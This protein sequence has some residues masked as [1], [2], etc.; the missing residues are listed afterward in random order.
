MPSV[1]F[2]PMMVKQISPKE[3]VLAINYIVPNM[4]ANMMLLMGGWRMPLQSTIFLFLESLKNRIVLSYML[5]D[6][7][8]GR[9]FLNTISEIS[10]ICGKLSFM[11]EEQLHMDVFQD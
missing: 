9:S 4:D 6:L 5:Q 7:F 10:M 8:L 11:E 2:A 1:E 3:F